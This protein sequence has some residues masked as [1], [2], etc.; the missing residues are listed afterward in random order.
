MITPEE[1]LCGIFTSRGGYFSVGRID[2]KQLEHYS[3]YADLSVEKLKEILPNN[4]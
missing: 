2:E 3:K 1:S 4:I